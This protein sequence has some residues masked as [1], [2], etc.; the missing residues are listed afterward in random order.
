MH[1]AYYN[2]DGKLMWQSP[3]EPL[4]LQDLREVLEGSKAQLH[5]YIWLL[6]P[7]GET[8]PADHTGA[9]R[10]L[11]TIGPLMFF[12]VVS[13]TSMPPSRIASSSYIS[14]WVNRLLTSG[15]DGEEPR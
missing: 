6:R 13:Y 4:T 8:L 5:R 14:D 3:S 12:V 11:A 10:T 2:L 1:I 9:L 7:G 15:R